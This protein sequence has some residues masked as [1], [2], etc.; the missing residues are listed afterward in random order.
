MFCGAIDKRMLALAGIPVM[1]HKAIP[2]ASVPLPLAPDGTVSVK[3]SAL[4]EAMV[5]LN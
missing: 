5:A 1:V 2:E 4:P 3:Y